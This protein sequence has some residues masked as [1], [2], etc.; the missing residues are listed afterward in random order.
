[1]VLLVLL[2]GGIMTALGFSGNGPLAFF[3]PTPTAGAAAT[4]AITGGRPSPTAGATSTP[5]APPTATLTPTPDPNAN[6][7]T[8]S[9]GTL[10]LND[11][12]VDNSQGHQW[13]VDSNS[14][15]ACQFSGG[16][17]QV[18][19]APHY[20]GPCFAR[21]TNFSS[22]TYQVDVTFLQQSSNQDG[23][24][25]VF[26]ADPGDP[27][28][29]NYTLAL[30][31]GGKYYLEVCV[32]SGVQ[33]ED[34][35]RVVF[36]GTCSTCTFSASQSDRL[37]IVASGNQFTFYVNGQNVASGTDSTYSQG[38]IGVEGSASDNPSI[39]AYQNARVWR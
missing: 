32:P 10:V 3:G 36:Q 35:S 15:N 11:P 38:L 22:F 12:L 33:G 18:V 16:S 20:G 25:I 9:M 2:L 30:Y 13:D 8:P 5:T 26:R 6:P 24:G 7:Y 4:T 37:A 23:A 34:C 29:K 39:M 31:V 1:M 28:R 14:G 19:R 17:Y 27:G 21:A